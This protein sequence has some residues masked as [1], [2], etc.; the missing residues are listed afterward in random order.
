MI[1]VTKRSSIG[2][3][4]ARRSFRAASA[5][6]GLPPV[7]GRYRTARARSSHRTKGDN[8]RRTRRYLGRSRCRVGSVYICVSSM[9]TLARRQPAATRRSHQTIS[10]CPERSGIGRLPGST[11]GPAANPP[12]SAWRR[13]CSSAVC[14]PAMLATSG[15]MSGSIGC[16]R[17]DRRYVIQPITYTRRDLRLGH[18][19]SASSRGR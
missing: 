6:T 15:G 18:L 2:L 9:C 1:F 8:A 5:T 19:L 17:S 3:L 12:P 14:C 16:D 10:G 7:R 4:S 11:P 13:C